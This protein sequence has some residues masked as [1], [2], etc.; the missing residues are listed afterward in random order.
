MILNTSTFSFCFLMFLLFYV[1]EL[2][3]SENLFMQ[4]LCELHFLLFLYVCVMSSMVVRFFSSICPK[5]THFSLICLALSNYNAPFLLQVDWSHDPAHCVQW[6][7]NAKSVFPLFHSQFYA[8]IQVLHVSRGNGSTATATIS[9]LWFQLPLNSENLLEKCNICKEN[10]NCYCAFI[11][12]WSVYGYGGSHRQ[13][14]PHP[15][16]E[17]SFWR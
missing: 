13:A 4:D 17:D 7:V 9:S 6:H 16:S 8:D 2:W 14:R 15:P 3:F 12:L 10:Y 1:M 11:D 5:R